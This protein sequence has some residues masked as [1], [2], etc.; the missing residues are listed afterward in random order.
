MRSSAF[1]R[2]GNK[3]TDVVCAV[4]DKRKRFLC[5]CCKDKLALLSVR[6]RLAGV[7]GNGTG[8]GDALGIGQEARERQKQGYKEFSHKNW[9]FSFVIESEFGQALAHLGG[10]H[11]EVPEQAAAVVFDHHGLRALVDGEIV[12]Q[13]WLRRTLVVGIV[14]AVFAQ[15]P[16]AHEVAQHAHRLHRGIDDGTDGRR[17]RHGAVLFRGHRMVGGISFLPVVGR[18]EAPEV[19][20]EALMAVRVG[21]GIFVM[22]EGMCAVAVE[23][24]AVAVAEAAGVEPEIGIMA[25]EERAAVLHSE[26]EFYAVVFLAVVIVVGCLVGGLVALARDGVRGRGG[27]EHIGYEGL[28]VALD[29]V[30]HLPFPVLRPVPVERVG[31]AGVPVPL[32]VAPQGVGLCGKGVAAFAAQPLAGSQQPLGHKGRLHEVAAVIEFTETEGFA[33]VAVVPVR[34]GAVETLDAAE[35]LRDFCD[36]GD[37]LVFGDVASLGSC[38]DGHHAET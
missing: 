9:L 1:T 23:I 17:G 35:R 36:A 15:H 28:V 25:E 37:A 20:A 7:V 38:D 12:L 31:A 22:D 13:H 24:V 8:D 29:T 19:F 4:A 16:V 11:K 32:D 3:R 18:S 33:G 34:P 2:L 6:K 14:E 30:V 10:T 5:N 21:L 26:R 27:A